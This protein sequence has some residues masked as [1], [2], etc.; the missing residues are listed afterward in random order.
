MQQVK[1]LVTRWSALSQ[2]MKPDAIAR[3][4]T[5]IQVGLLIV[6]ISLG[7]AISGKAEREGGAKPIPVVGRS[8]NAGF[9]R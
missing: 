4:G 1:R 2:Q 7:V 3:W 5:W 8:E 9:Q 6:F